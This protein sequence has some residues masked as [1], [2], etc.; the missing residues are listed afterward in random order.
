MAEAG[1]LIGFREDMEAFFNFLEI[2][3]FY[4]I[5]QLA[6]IC[7]SVFMLSVTDVVSVAAVIPVLAASLSN[8]FAWDEFLVFQLISEAL[9]LDINNINT[10]YYLILIMISICVSSLF[11]KMFHDG[12]LLIY[13]HFFFISIMI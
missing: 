11:L 3:R 2:V 1:I 12:C 13:P 7:L 10:K 4:R 8:Q 5:R 9:S 6:F